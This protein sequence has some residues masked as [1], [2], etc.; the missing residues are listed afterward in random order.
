MLQQRIP[1]II[2]KLFRSFI[3]LSPSYYEENLEVDMASIED[4]GK[5]MSDIMK[6][7]LQ[8]QVVLH[9]LI[10][11]DS[12]FMIVRIMTAKP[13][14]ETTNGEYM[15]WKVQVVDI[16][17]TMEMNSEVCQYL[18]QRRCIDILVRIW[19]ECLSKDYLTLLDHRE[20]MLTLNLMHYQ[21]Y[22]SAKIHYFGLM[23]EMLQ[24]SGYEL[25]CKFLKTGPYNE[26]TLQLKV[27]T[28]ES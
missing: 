11:E 6:Q 28:I 21:F 4:V 8:N 18:H 7:F 16:L 9:R 22:G 15:K 19:R 3:D 12:V 26:S 23:D 5:V 14:I 10:T 27:S 1:S 17:K 2:I 20:I 24:A 25:L 13:T